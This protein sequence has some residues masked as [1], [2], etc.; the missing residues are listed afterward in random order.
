MTP[1]AITTK[2]KAKRTTV[3]RDRVSV[4][5][6]PD[7]LPAGKAFCAVCGK[8]KPVADFYASKTSKSGHSFWCKDC[9]KACAAQS[10]AASKP[11]ETTQAA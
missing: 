6:K 7:R 8:T 9:N 5:P 2:P 1:L 11:A 10:R 3:K 4:H